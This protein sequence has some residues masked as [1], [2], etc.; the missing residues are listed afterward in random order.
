MKRLNYLFALLIVGGLIFASA[1][2]EEETIDR[3]AVLMDTLWDTSILDVTVS[4]AFGSQAY[5]VV[6]EM[7][8]CTKDDLLDFVTESQYNI[9]DSDLSCDAPPPNGILFT[10]SWNLSGNTLE[11]DADYFDQLTTGMGISIA[12][13]ATNGAIL[14]NVVSLSQ[15]KVE[16]EF[17]KIIPLTL[18]GTTVTVD[19][20]ITIEVTLIP[21]P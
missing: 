15:E 7:D 5:D 6:A 2:T 10:G 21:A 3:T 8:D 20:D 13:L 1:C 16:L 14:F 19:S 12:D 11:L 17:T 4:N 18:P 9:L